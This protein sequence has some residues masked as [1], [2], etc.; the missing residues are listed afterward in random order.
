[1]MLVIPA[2][3]TMDRF[4]E[5]LPALSSWL[6]A[7]GVDP[8]NVSGLRELSIT[9]DQVAGSYRTTDEKFFISIG[10]PMPEDL[11]GYLAARFGCVYGEGEVAPDNAF[12][13]LTGDDEAASL[14]D[15]AQWVTALATARREEK[16]AKERAE[17]ARDQILARLKATGK[18]Y[19]TV[20]GNRVVH[21]K[22]IES[23]R[24][25]TT[26]F[27][28]EHPALAELYTSVSVSTRLEI[29]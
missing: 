2:N 25:K 28:E 9:T 10:V 18:E 23:S 22:K 11:L 21:A 3:T 27:R 17:E 8:A 15:M 20:G 24:F 26:A 1:M 5:A 7:N 6:D 13:R 19:G 4:G 16:S 12:Q 29:L 14:D